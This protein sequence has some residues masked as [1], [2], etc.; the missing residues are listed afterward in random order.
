MDDVVGGCIYLVYMTE[1]DENTSYIYKG[2]IILQTEK[3]V[4]AFDGW[5]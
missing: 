2:V 5:F 4:R 1:N 3:E